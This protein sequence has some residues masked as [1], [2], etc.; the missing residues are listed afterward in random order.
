[1]IIF[2]FDK[3][4]QKKSFE[5]ICFDCNFGW[6]N[7]VCKLRRRVV[8]GCFS[9]RIRKFDYLPVCLAINLFIEVSWL[10]PK[11]LFNAYILVSKTSEGPY[12]LDQLFSVSVLQTI[13]KLMLS[14][15]LYNAAKFYSCFPQI[16]KDSWSA[17]SVRVEFRKDTQMC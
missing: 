17:G 6:K 14:L 1:M 10:N 11:F 2:F 8:L 5:S 13:D 12:L 9:Y 3:S 7:H 4:L 15:L 16:S